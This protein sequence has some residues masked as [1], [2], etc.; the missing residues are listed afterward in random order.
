MSLNIC[1]HPWYHHHDQGNRHIPYLP[2]SWC[3]FVVAVYVCIFCF[4]VARVLNMRSTPLTN[5]NIGSIVLLTIDIMLYSRS[6][7]LV[8]LA[9]LNHYIHWIISLHLHLSSGYGN[10]ITFSVSINSTAIYPSY[11][12]NHAVFFL[13]WLAYFM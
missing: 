12:W 8:H 4:L 9:E 7:D 2:L 10:T 1:R 6:L 11:K 3:P 5:F 13:L